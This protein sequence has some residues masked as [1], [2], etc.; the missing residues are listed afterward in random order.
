MVT[1]CDYNTAHNIDIVNARSMSDREAGIAGS[2][3]TALLQRFA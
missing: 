3:A 1:T 2:S